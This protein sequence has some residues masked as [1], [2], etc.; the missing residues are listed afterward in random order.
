MIPAV[1]P[2][3]PNPPAGGEF[4]SFYSNI[5]YCVN[6]ITTIIVPCVAL[7]IVP[8]AIQ[9]MRIPRF[10]FQSIG[11]SKLFFQIPYRSCKFL[12][13]ILFNTVV[14]SSKILQS[15]LIQPSIFL[16]S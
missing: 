16:S 11:T 2:L 8:F 14:N 7:F 9:H 4:G 13:V 5:N 12:N 3:T 1:L 10:L 15:C 6:C